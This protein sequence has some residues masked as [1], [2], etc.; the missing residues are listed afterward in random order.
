MERK[1]YIVNCENR[2]IQKHAT[3]IIYGESEEEVR[4]KYENSFIYQSGMHI[5]SIG[6]IPDF[7]L[8]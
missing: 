7:H 8:L 6:E 2:N 3:F 4:K 1:A 5:I